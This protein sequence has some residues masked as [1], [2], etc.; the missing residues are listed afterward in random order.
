MEQVAAVVSTGIPRLVT[1]LGEPG[2]GK[3]RLLGELAARI[4]AEHAERKLRHAVELA[5]RQDG[6]ETAAWVTG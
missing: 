5:L 2:I 1:V 3:T 6:P 4:A